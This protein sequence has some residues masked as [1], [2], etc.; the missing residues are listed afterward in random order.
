MSE[1][2]IAFIEKWIAENIS[3]EALLEGGAAPRF[4]ELATNALHAAQVSGIP[5]AE[6]L[7]EFPDL[8]SR[9]AAAIQGAAD[10]E[11]RRQLDHD[12]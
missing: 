6:I 5:D 2:G 12:D 10:S 4:D 3:A 7:E 8:S 11:L 9:M 1:R